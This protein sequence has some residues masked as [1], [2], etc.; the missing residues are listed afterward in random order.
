MRTL[1]YTNIRQKT[2]Q[3]LFKNDLLLRGGQSFL[4]W[5]W[6]DFKVVL[7]KFSFF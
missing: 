5:S 3:T 4:K 6:Q 7:D 1:M 2:I